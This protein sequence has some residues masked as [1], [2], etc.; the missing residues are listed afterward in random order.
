MSYVYIQDDGATIHIDG[1]RLKVLKNDTSSVEVP[2]EIIEGLS[3]IGN[4]HMTTPC[5]KACLKRGISTTFFSKYGTYY[6]KLSSVTHR[7]VKREKQQMILFDDTEFSLELTK[8]IL[9]GKINNQLITLKRCARGKNILLDENIKFLSI[10]R[11]KMKTAKSIESAIGYEGLA[12]KYYFQGL[13]SLLPSE[14]QFQGRSTRPPK[15]PFNAMI[16]F[17]YTLLLGQIYGQLEMRGL[18]PY[19]GFLHQDRRK[20]PALVSDMMEEWRSIIVDSIVVHMIQRKEIVNEHFYQ[21][22]DE[23]GIFLQDD[24]LKILIQKL[25][26]KMGT[27]QSYIVKQKEKQDFRRAIGYQIDQLVQVIE[28]GD[29]TKYQPIKIR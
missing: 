3:I 29:P 7:N 5:M 6:G 25:E 15:D 8:R 10:A 28:K 23:K 4:A 26:K 12:A 20:H 9:E 13:S 24:G 16:S 1:G 27:K 11:G 17:G 18:N 19:I 21:K 2:V 14:F 22:K